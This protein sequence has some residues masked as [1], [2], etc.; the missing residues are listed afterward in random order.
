MAILYNSIVYKSIFREVNSSTGLK[1]FM[2]SS[3]KLNCAPVL[4]SPDSPTK[5]QIF[6][7]DT[8]KAPSLLDPPSAN[9]QAP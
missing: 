7:Y 8:H 1:L 4:V 2:H 3:D 9:H 6:L 5:E